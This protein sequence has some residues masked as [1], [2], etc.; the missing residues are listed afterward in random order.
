MLLPPTRGGPPSPSNFTPRNMQSFQPWGPMRGPFTPPTQVPST[1][2]GLQGLLQRFLPSKLLSQVGSGGGGITQ[3][4]TN[5]QQILKMT[6][7]VTPL[8]QQYGPLMKNLPSM[9]SLL[10]AFQETESDDEAEEKDT[11]EDIDLLEVDEE[12]E[13]AKDQ[14]EQTVKPNKLD[15]KETLNIIETNQSP[16][17]RS[18]QSAPKLYI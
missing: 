16:K 18:N 17:K 13:D 8:I 15:A 6:Q 14:E 5:L 12:D 1:S 11:D 3:T 10:K 7:S 9:I 4:L 2:S